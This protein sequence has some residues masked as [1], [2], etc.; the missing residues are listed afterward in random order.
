MHL[1]LFVVM[2]LVVSS[3]RHLIEQLWFLTQS[4]PDALRPLAYAHY[5]RERL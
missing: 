5:Y 3:P 1:N 4:Q 2:L